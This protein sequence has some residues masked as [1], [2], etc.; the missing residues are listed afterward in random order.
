MGFTSCFLSQNRS[1]AVHPH[2][3]GVYT[4]PGPFASSTTGPSPRAWGLLQVVLFR[5]F[6]NRSIPTCVGFT[7]FVISGLA[8][9]SGPS[10]RS[11]GLLPCPRRK[12]CSTRSI[13]TFV[14]FTHTA[15]WRSPAQPVHPHVRG[16]YVKEKL[17]E[18][19]VIGPSP[20][21]WGLLVPGHIGLE[22]RRSIPTF[23]GFTPPPRRTTRLQIGPSPRS[24]GLRFTLGIISAVHRSIPTFVGFTLK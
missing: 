4:V 23:V 21:S 18:D 1:N 15:P 20:R 24:W 9:A 11:W 22:Q 13:P 10:P 3:R 8:A 14:G 19:C 17:G 7:G 5:K 12:R 2:V 6:C 16:V